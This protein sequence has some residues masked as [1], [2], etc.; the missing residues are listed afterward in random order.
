MSTAE[1]VHTHYSLCIVK[2]NFVLF[3]LLRKK[4]N[5]FH[6]MGEGGGGPFLCLPHHWKILKKRT[7]PMAFVIKINMLP[8][9]IEQVVAQGVNDDVVVDKD[10][11]LFTH[12]TTS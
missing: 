6:C 2:Y 7:E 8:S 10:T 1:N 11:I 5:E 12:D 4:N 3:R 9:V